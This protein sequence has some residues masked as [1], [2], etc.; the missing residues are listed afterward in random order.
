MG[1]KLGVIGSGASD[2]APGYGSRCY[3]SANRSVPV[4]F[5]GDRFCWNHFFAQFAVGGEYAMESCQVDPGLGNESGEAANELQGAENGVGS[6]LV[7]RG[8]EPVD[9]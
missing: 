9:T 4:W 2:I 5:G 8:L 3:V 6:T 7:V 1:A